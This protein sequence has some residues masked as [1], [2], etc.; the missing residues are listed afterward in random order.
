VSSAEV[1][2]SANFRI[3]DPVM[4]IGG[5]RSTSNNFTLLQSL[6]QLAAGESSATSF[7]LNAGFL[8]Y[9]TTTI[10]FVTATA[11]DAS[12]SLSWT[13]AIGFLGWTVSGYT[14]G[15]STSSGGPYTYTS[16]ENVTSSN[17]TGLSN[18]TTYFFVVLPE[19]AFG[20]TI[21]TSSEVSSVPVASE[22]VEPEPSGE[23]G[24]V[25]GLITT[26]VSP[27]AA[28]L[29]SPL[30]PERLLPKI[31]RIIPAI[32]RA[33]DLDGDRRIGLKDLSIYLFYSIHPKEFARADINRD[34]KVDLKDLST[35]FYGWTDEIDVALQAEEKQEDTGEFFTV[36]EESIVRNVSRDTQVATPAVLSAPQEP[37]VENQE[38]KAIEKSPGLFKRFLNSIKELFSSLTT[39]I[40]G[41]AGFR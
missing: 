26:F 19:D 23:G 3:V 37:S 38:T 41:V 2:S 33:A 34:G 35:M 30:I 21:A 10:P 24:T 11:G 4:D 31:L 17:R 5:G 20:T 28:F 15:Q 13:A 18:G 12:V 40:A 6:G 29:I 39:F 27:L 1:L 16:I 9:P 32:A 36:G 14:I 22:D 8:T 25:V 7:Q